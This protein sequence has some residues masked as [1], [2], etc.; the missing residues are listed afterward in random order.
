MTAR[1]P[2]GNPPRS[3]RHGL[4]DRLAWTDGPGRS[5]GE[6]VV[7][8][9]LDPTAADR[10]PRYRLRTF[11]EGRQSETDLVLPEG[12]VFAVPRWEH[13]MPRDERLRH[14]RGQ[15]LPWNEPIPDE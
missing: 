10:Q 4:G 8:E 11:V 15:T 13:E 12:V 1:K 5:A 7:A 2:G 9:L 6:G 3:H 14:H